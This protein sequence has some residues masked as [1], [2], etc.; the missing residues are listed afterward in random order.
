MTV[1]T[2]QEREL[3]SKFRI[4]RTLQDRETTPSSPTLPSYPFYA[5][6]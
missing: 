3:N 5:E 4:F 1:S 6:I 2:L